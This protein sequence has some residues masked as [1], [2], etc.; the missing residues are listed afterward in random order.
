MAGGFSSG[1]DSGFGSQPLS[2]QSVSGTETFT[3]ALSPILLL[4]QVLTGEIDFDGEIA[5]SNPDWLLI[6][7]EL[8]W[9][10]EW[11]E[12]TEYNLNDVVLHHTGNE[13]HVFVSKATHNVGNTPTNSP[14]YWRRLYQEKWQ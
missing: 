10:G 3:G 7:E 4:L 5:V 9:M 8:M 11:L 1:F 2:Y 14:A 13:W 12:T 6:D